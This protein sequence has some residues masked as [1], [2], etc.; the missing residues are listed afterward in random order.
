MEGELEKPKQ[1][2]ELPP[3]PWWAGSVAMR[4]SPVDF[5]SA[6]AEAGKGDF[7]YSGYR[8]SRPD[9][10]LEYHFSRY[11]RRRAGGKLAEIS[12]HQVALRRLAE[13]TGGVATEEQRVESPRFRVLFGLV[14]GYDASKAITHTPTE[15]RTQLGDEVAITPVE[16][17]AIGGARAVKYT[18]P[19]VV[20]EG[21]MTEL[22]K[23]YDLAD[24]FHQDRII[25]EDLSKGVS[26]T[27]ETRWC[28]EPDPIA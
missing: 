11:V 18:E 7:R 8:L 4:I 2:R 10:A 1:F 16:I 6:I 20:V 22:P 21:P 13:I 15:I 24:A 14:E 9:G 25:I 23:V 27:V 26:Y 3:V 19:A 17:F 5:E 12:E 28:K